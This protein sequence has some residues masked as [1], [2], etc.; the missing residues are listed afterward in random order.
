VAV[1]LTTDHSWDNA[2][3]FGD[4]G[5]GGLTNPGNNITVSADGYYRIQA[6]LSNMTY[7]LVLENW[8]VIGDAT[9]NSW[10]DETPLTYNQ[11][12]DT[13]RGGI[14]M[15]AGSFKIQSQP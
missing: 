1:K 4:D 10:N 11:T 7:S 12:T 5:S 15:T 8:G 2:H 9:P 13:W 14:H 3:T 6:N